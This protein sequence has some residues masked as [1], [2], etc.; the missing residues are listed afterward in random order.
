MIAFL[1]FKTDQCFENCG[2]SWVGGWNNR[3]NQTDWLCNLLDAVSCIFLDHTAGFGIAVCIV[4]IFCCVVV[5]DY[6]I[7]HNAHSGFFYCQFCQW[8]SCLVSSDSSSLENLIYLLLCVGSEDCLRSSYFSDL[9]VRASS[10]STMPTVL[11]SL[12]AI[13]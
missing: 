2:G 8:D 9:A 6:L 4:D 10:V 5:F 3:S 12:F 13:K 7:F 1:V 11:A